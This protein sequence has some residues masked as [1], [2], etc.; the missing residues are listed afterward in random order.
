[1]KRCMHMEGIK[2]NIIRYIIN[3]NGDAHFNHLIKLGCTKRQAAVILQ[4]LSRSEFVDL[5]D[6]NSEILVYLHSQFF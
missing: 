5:Y 2:N 3:R 4:I 1:M 6:N